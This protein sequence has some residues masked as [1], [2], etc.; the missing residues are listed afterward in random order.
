MVS[1]LT[2]DSKK[3][4]VNQQV[5]MPEDSPGFSNPSLFAGPP[6]VYTPAMAVWW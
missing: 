2:N 6:S 4:W 1:P 3:Q 5:F